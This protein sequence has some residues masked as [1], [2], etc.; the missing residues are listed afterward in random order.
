[1]N[2]FSR[3]EYSI[4]DP[5][6]SRNVA[7]TKNYEKPQP[8]AGGDLEAYINGILVPNIDAVTWSTS[9]EIVGQY[10][11]GSRDPSAFT[12]GKR[13]IVGSM[14]FQQWDKHAILEE[15]FRLSDYEANR[16][17][18]MGRLWDAESIGAYLTVNEPTVQGVV[19]SSGNTGGVGTPSITSVPST[20]DAL[21]AINTSTARGLSRAEFQQMNLEKIRSTAIRMGSKRVRYTDQIP[22]FD[23]TLVGVNAN[24]VAATCTI[25][26]IEI[27]QE[28]DGKSMND[29]NPTVGFSFVARE[30]D[31]WRR[32]DKKTL[33]LS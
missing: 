31:Y 10:R 3:R 5:A 1:M 26:G 24:G 32:V 7:S 9:T 25:Y 6:F 15:V 29:L 17:L 18:T 19:S 30:Y 12:K 23:L 11:F 14:S 2:V 13:V 8:M 20:D 4:A 22:P 16:A 33:N 27:Q 21:S 28:T